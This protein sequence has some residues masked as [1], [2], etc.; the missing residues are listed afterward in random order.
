MER[1]TQMTDSE[2]EIEAALDQRARRAAKRVGLKAVR[3]RSRRG[4]IDNQGGFQLIEPITNG[5]VAGVRLDLSA[6]Q[7]IA[8]C[9][10][11]ETG[12]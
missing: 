9:A 12:A 2:T 7:V 1:T 4:S 8:F 5:I 11:R 3:S 6:E 10:D